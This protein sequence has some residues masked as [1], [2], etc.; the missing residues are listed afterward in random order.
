MLFAS[1]CIL[2]V[3]PFVTGDEDAWNQRVNFWQVYSSQKLVIG[4]MT[5][6]CHEINKAKHQRRGKIIWQPD[7]NI[8][9]EEQ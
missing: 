5:D 3:G 8:P 6:K 9:S 7:N 2:I 1:T 4:I